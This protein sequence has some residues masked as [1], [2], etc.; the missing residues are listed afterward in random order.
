V[1]IWLLL[2][3]STSLAAS[4][5]VITFAQQGPAKTI[6]DGVYTKEQAIRGQQAYKQTCGYCHR[7][8]MSGSE[9]AGEL[10][11][12]LVGVF[13]VLRWG[14]PLSQLFIKI[15]DEM[16]KDAPG[17]VTSEAAA[18]IVSYLLEANDAQAGTTELPPDRERLKQIL[19]TKK[20]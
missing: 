13:F 15:D 8:D 2:A 12:E 14:G 18:D 9:V 6:W 20:P 11:P 19:V 4:A 3:A 16:P 7:S 1:K 5:I 10:A 17:T